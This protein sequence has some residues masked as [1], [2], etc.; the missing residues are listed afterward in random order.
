MDFSNKENRFIKLSEVS[1]EYIEK[2]SNST[3]NDEF[4]PSF[5]IAPRHGLVNDPNGL[6]QIN[7]VH[8]IFYQWFPL[9]PVHGLKHWYHITTRDFINYDD[10]G[11]ALN[12][13]ENYEE[14]GCFS[15][16]TFIEDGKVNVF[17]TGN[18]IVDGVGVQ[19]QCLTTLN[20][21]NDKLEK[22]GV[23]IEP[24]FD[25]YTNEFRDPIIFKREDSYNMLIGA[26]NKKSEG[27]IAL[28]RGTDINSF[29]HYGY[30]NLLKEAKGYMIECPNYYE[31]DDKG[32]MI[33]SPQGIESPDKYTYRNVFS[34]LYSI[35]E[36]IDLDNIKYRSNV[37]KELDKGFDFY[38]PQ[39]YKDENNRRIMIGWLGNSK[40]EYPT[41]KNM[42]AHM[43]TLP[44]E[45]IVKNN[46]IYQKVVDEMY[47]LKGDSVKVELEVN[48]KS[49]SFLLELDVEEN[50]EIKIFNEKGHNVTFGSENNEFILNRENMTTL[51]AE[52]FG[53]IRYAKRINCNKQRIEI[54]F[55]SSAMEI[56]CDDGATVF[57]SRIFIENIYKVKFENVTG[58]LTYLNS[59]NL[60]YNKKL[61]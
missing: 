52:K 59:I 20:L 14:H 3:K 5:H 11:I 58:E 23:V 35:G 50:F 36:L 56:F 16:S 40:S 31:D 38:A 27:V 19:S 29:K 39:V 42:W 7:G 25:Y 30:I 18:K 46:T 57:T 24:N 33:F 13:E 51:Y 37:F 45:I 2:I 26:Q 12:P 15:G 60:N 17:Y 41:D 34:V 55:D 22:K 9:G 49:R 32:V 8:H 1:N 61:L 4:Y 44:R 54:W 28:Y 47:S 53:N 48:L 43:L 21:E 10:K 6:C